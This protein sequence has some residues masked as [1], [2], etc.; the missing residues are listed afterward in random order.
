MMQEFEHQVKRQYTGDALQSFPVELPGVKD[1][2]EN[3]IVDGHI[4]LKP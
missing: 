4:I 3:G 1:D 2:L